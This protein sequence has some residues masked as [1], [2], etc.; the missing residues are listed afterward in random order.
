VENLPRGDEDEGGHHQA[1]NLI[2]FWDMR[3]RFGL[4]NRPTLPCN[5][6]SFL[7]FETRPEFWNKK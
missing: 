1:R 7:P 2:R 4:I 5:A 3:G 6:L